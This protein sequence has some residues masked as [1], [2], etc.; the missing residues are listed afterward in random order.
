MKDFGLQEFGHDLLNFDPE[1]VADQIDKLLADQ[2]AI[3][4]IVD[5]VADYS[6]QLDLQFAHVAALCRRGYSGS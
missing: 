6:R 4:R 5:R 1:E 3:E 2:H